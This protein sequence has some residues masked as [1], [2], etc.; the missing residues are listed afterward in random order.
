MGADGGANGVDGQLVLGVSSPQCR[1]V[2]DILLEHGVRKARIAQRQ[3]HGKVDAARFFDLL[4]E[5]VTTVLGTA[6]LAQLHDQ[7]VLGGH[8][9]LNVEQRAHSARSS[10]QA[11][12]TH[13]VLQ[14]L[15][16]TDNHHTVA[17]GLDG[18]RDLGRATAL[19]H[20]AQRILDQHALA[21]GDV[22]AIYHEHVAARRLGKCGTG[23]LI[24]ARK[25]SAHGN[26]HSLIAGITRLG[27]S[28]R[29]RVR[30]DLAGLGQLIALHEH[31]VKALVIDV[32]AIHVHIGAKGDGQRQNTQSGVLSRRHIARGIG[33]NTN[34]HSESFLSRTSRGEF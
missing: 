14:R 19:V 32:D 9:G 20:Q 1:A 11:T 27:N 23:T 22:V 34:G 2:L 7:A 15:E 24:G 13:Q 18:R 10:R 25:L 21:Q 5:Q 3:R 17:H 30:V 29:K 4:V 33:N 26:N 16:Q 31:L 12:A 6:R 8:H 28:L